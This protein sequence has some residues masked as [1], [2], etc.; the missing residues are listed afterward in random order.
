MRCTTTFHRVAGQVEAAVDIPRLHRAD[1]IAGEAT[2]NRVEK[3]ALIGTK[4]AMSRTF[5]TDR[6]AS[7]GIEVIVPDA[8]KHDRINSVIYDELVHGRVLDPARRRMVELTDGVRKG[9]GKGRG[10]AV[11]VD[12]GGRRAI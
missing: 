3:L 1:V 4:F 12:H 6:I 5:F 10:G 9:D 2:A 8:E 7:H 11:R